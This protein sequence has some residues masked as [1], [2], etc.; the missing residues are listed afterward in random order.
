MPLSAQPF[1][2]T[3]G[4]TLTV[5]PQTN[6]Y[7]LL[8]N[9]LAKGKE[10][11]N[12]VQDYIGGGHFGAAPVSEGRRVGVEIE[13]EGVRE[14][15]DGAYGPLPLTTESAHLWG[16]WWK[17]KTDGSLR[18]SGAEFMTQPLLLTQALD[19]LEEFY[20][21]W[22]KR[23]TWDGSIRCG[24][25]VHVD[26]RD[27]TMD[28]FGALFTAYSLV[29]PALFDFVGKDRE[30]CIYCIPWY[31]APN[32]ADVL[33]KKVL[34]PK[35]NMQNF[36]PA[37]EGGSHINHRLS[38]YSALFWSPLAWYGTVEFR[39]A[40]T[41]G[42][43]YYTRSWVKMCYSIV[44][45]CSKR[46][47]AQV[48]Q[49]W[50]ANKREFLYNLT[51]GYM[52]I[53][54]EAIEAVDFWDIEERIERLHK[55]AVEDAWKPVMKETGLAKRKP[56]RTAVRAVKVPKVASPNPYGQLG[57]K[58]PGMSLAEWATHL[59]ELG[60]LG[61]LSPPV[62]ASGQEL[63]YQAASDQYLWTSAPVPPPPPVP[64]PPQPS[65]SLDWLYDE[66]DDPD[67]E[68]LETESL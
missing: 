30:E 61:Q 41:W 67:E 14:F 38:K 27:Y 13:I 47:E 36:M 49:E 15:H 24:I 50:K 66:L 17:I 5:S 56:R 59:S 18:N 22:S 9:K 8:R 3:S 23:P 65:P 16:K 12:T 53:H 25:H 20:G 35:M 62:T 64:T 54:K 40:P 31:R 57:N 4:A 39:H 10:N 68:I 21:E 37:V 42:N 51:G 46:T 2:N 28:N 43:Q 1:L 48:W 55:V 44:D 34:A 32:D 7:I 33:V 29:E 26:C 11:M 52:P 63:M 19:A 60:P 6:A 45:Y 58:P